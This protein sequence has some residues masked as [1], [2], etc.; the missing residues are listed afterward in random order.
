MDRIP[1]EVTGGVLRTT[2]L[3]GNCEIKG[4]IAHM[5]PPTR[6]TK[7]AETVSKEMYVAGSTDG[8]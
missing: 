6:E 2:V 4:A 3:R 7:I 8:A 5:A 1:I